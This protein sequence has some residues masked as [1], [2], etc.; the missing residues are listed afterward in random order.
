MKY[1]LRYDGK[2][3]KVEIQK[4][5]RFFVITMAGHKQR[6]ISDSDYCYFD[7]F[8]QAKQWFMEHIDKKINLARNRLALLEQRKHK[9]LESNE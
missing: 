2:I 3:D 9:V 6:K 4:D 1:R 7:T 8:E 5:T